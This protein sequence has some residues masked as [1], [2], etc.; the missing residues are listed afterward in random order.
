LF[1]IGF[2]TKARS[3]IEKARA[4]IP[5]ISSIWEESIKL[6]IKCNNPKA[7]NLLMSKALQECPQSGKL[8]ALAIELE[9]KYQKNARSVDALKK[10]EH[11]PYVMMAIAK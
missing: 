5:K 6:E 2:E 9:P 10:C 8:W 3:I 4:I 1:S 11:D 7:A